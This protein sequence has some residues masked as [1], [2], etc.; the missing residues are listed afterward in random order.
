VTWGVMVV[1]GL[2]TYL[3]RLSFIMIWG[4]VRIPLI[5]EK[6]LKFVPSAILSALIVPDLFLQDSQ[7]DVSLGNLRFLAG[8]IAILVAWKTRS[9]LLTIVT[10]MVVLIVLEWISWNG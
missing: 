5:V 7:F 9:A 6:G 1:S 8:I 4:R 3:I 10:G 2:I